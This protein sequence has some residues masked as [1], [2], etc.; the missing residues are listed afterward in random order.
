[1]NVVSSGG[2]RED[3]AFYSAPLKNKTFL[4]S[5]SL[6]KFSTLV[7]DTS[8]T[9]IGSALEHVSCPVVCSFSVRFTLNWQNYS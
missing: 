4:P 2:F 3:V 9:G 5:F 1:M 6:L 7:T 8:P